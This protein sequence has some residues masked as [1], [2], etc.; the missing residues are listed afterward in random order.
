MRLLPWQCGPLVYR[1]L[2]KRKVF[3]EP[4]VQKPISEETKGTLSLEAYQNVESR[5]D[6]VN[7]LRQL[8]LTEEE[9]ELKLRSE[10]LDR[11]GK[12]HV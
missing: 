10:G 7:E 11:E 2:S 1:H 5:L 6:Y 12:V 8:G 3:T 4:A 9:V